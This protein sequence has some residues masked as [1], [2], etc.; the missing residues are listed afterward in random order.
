MSATG[1]IERDQVEATNSERP[2]R[3]ERCDS[4]IQAA[5]WEVQMTAGPL[6]FCQHHYSRWSESF[7]GRPVVR[8]TGE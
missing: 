5:R 6:N 8:L 1:V 7:V 3:D 2:R 4:C